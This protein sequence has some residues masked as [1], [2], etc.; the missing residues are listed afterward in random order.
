MGQRSLDDAEI[1]GVELPPPTY[2]QYAHY[3]TSDR[4]SSLAVGDDFNRKASGTLCT[5]HGICSW[6]EEG[7]ADEHVSIVADDHLQLHY[8]AGGVVRPPT[9]AVI[10]G[11]TLRDGEVRGR[12]RGFN[13]SYMK[14]RPFGFSYR[15]QGAAV[16]HDDPGYHLLITSTGVRLMAGGSQ[17]A[18]SVY[19]VDVAWHDY[20]IVF[21]GDR[22]RVYMDGQLILD[23][24]DATYPNTGKV[25]V[26]GYYSVSEFDDISARALP[27]QGV[28]QPISDDF[29][30]ADGD[31][32]RTDRMD[33]QWSEE[34]GS[35]QHVSVQGGALQFHY[36]AGGS[37]HP[38]SWAV[39]NGLSLQN[40]EIRGR[41]RGY[42]E[43]YMTNRPFGFSYRLQGATAEHDAAGYHVLISASGVRLMAGA[44]QVGEWANTVDADWHDYRIEVV[45]DRHR[46]FMDG[47]PAPILDVIDVSYPDAGRVGVAGY[48]SISSFEH[49]SARALPIGG[50]DPYTL[51]MTLLYYSVEPTEADAVREQGVNTGQAYLTTEQGASA[52]SA[53]AAVETHV[54]G[55]AA[56]GMRVMA[57][58]GGQF[59]AASY[60]TT[61][62][63]IKTDVDAA[64]MALDS[65]ANVSFWY[66]PEELRYWYDNEKAEGIN[67]S[68]WAQDIDPQ[69]RPTLMYTPTHGGRSRFYAEFEWAHI[70]LGGAY[71]GFGAMDPHWT[72][73]WARW[74]VQELLD[75]VHG[76]YHLG[77]DHQ[78]GGRT[79]M[80]AGWCN[81]D[82]PTF[83]EAEAYNFVF[84]TLAE[85]ARG[86]GVWSYF[87]GK[88]NQ[89]CLD[90]Y[91]AAFNILQ[92]STYSLGRA[93]LHGSRGPLLVVTV[94]AGQA[95]TEPF[96]NDPALPAQRLPS[97]VA[98]L[99]RFEGKRYI[100][101]ANSRNDSV[102]V[103]FA[104]AGRSGQIEVLTEGRSVSMVNGAFI[105]TFAAKEVHLYV[106]P[107]G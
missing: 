85:G 52:A 60:P 68:R 70:L 35:D 23:A 27:I 90:G 66:L 42:S 76:E 63:S 20:R 8:F 1:G 107:P 14:D 89:P 92:D 7:D 43:S 104:N 77:S 36:F 97:V 91:A 98:T 86:I 46:V 39:I 58:L 81:A 31:L 44:T 78:E 74:K 6:T 11:V 37:V 50:L 48:Y 38:R 18:A 87:H 80:I 34:G 75:A 49:I 9:W 64:V 94:T 101:A 25:G 105:D 51:D 96:K 3:S 71:V 26:A 69:N 102:T 4:K 54:A 12:A 33:V 61:A 40:L 30:R 103:G 24:I 67:L 47:G 65:Y 95:E 17:V 10:K 83:A 79:P 72:L 2:P 59:I 73:A 62:N 53:A 56:E 99:V 15:L 57:S 29:E 106:L 100:I 5:D 13:E 19:S 16:D 55:M 45:G 84:S 41:A 21:I 82:E 28:G 32:L 93:L 22:H 88:K